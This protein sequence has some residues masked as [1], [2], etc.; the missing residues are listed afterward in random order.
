MHIWRKLAV[1]IIAGALLA[2]TGIGS[3]LADPIRSPHAVNFTLTCD[4]TQLTVVSANEP[5]A[6]IQVVGSTTTLVATDAT[7]T[8]TYTDPQT[9]ATVTEVQS[10]VYGAA[11][12]NA[13]GI[14]KRLVTC[15]NTITV[16]DPNVGLVTVALTGQFIFA[17]HV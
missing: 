11:H 4:G 13:T 10:V 1:A 17:P 15:T 7:L 14:E 2:G 9:G 12:G 5:T 6:S 16:Q 8:T 3:A